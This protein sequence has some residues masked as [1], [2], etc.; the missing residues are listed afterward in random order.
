MANNGKIEN[1]LGDIRALERLVAG[2]QEEDACP[3]S[4]FGETFQLTHQILKKLYDLETERIERFRK[5][6][7]EHRAM[8]EAFSDTGWQELHREAEKPEENSFTENQ[9]VE[10][11]PL[12]SSRSEII[13][14]CERMPEPAVREESVVIPEPVA[15][16]ASS[17]AAE[18]ETVG[19]PKSSLVEKQGLFLNDLLEKQYL[20]DFR[21][22]FS[23]NDRF[24][25]RRELFE[26]D[27]EKMNQAIADL[28]EIGSYDEAMVYLQQTLKWNMEEEAVGDFVKLLEKRYL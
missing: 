15:E 6:V 5:Q 17:V 18:S 24:R 10:E 3:V 25:F 20:S 26:G 11:V 16:A 19:A 27:E 4:F 23:L 12:S 8:I 14:A 21:K 9:Q 1:L 2:V 13:S 22:A 7:L 28:N